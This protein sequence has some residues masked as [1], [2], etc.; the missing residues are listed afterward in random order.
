MTKV[1]L[2]L[3]NKRQVFPLSQPN[4]FSRTIVIR[5]TG[6]GEYVVMHVADIMNYHYMH[7]V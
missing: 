4:G 5:M 3:I 7:R 6:R 2:N 1:F